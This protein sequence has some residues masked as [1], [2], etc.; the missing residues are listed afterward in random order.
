M[1]AI[2]YQRL[3][4]EKLMLVVF[5]ALVALAWLS[6]WSDRVGRFW[7]AQH[8]T[9]VTLKE[10]A[11]WIG[12]KDRINADVGRAFEHLDP[13]RT[14][15]AAKLVGEL[16]SIASSAGLTNTAGEAPRTEQNEQGSVN[17]VQF[18]ISKADI[19]ALLRFYGEVSK[20]SP[21]LNIEQLAL[22]VDRTNPSLLNASMKISSIEFTR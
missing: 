6:N 8:R 22:N 17:T 18:T 21:Y 5:A 19:A 16:A 2:F 4:R 14:L 9:T 1:K 10:Q 3:L 11:L 15:N 13:A 12:N 7:T 20:R